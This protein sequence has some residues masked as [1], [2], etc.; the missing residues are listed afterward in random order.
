MN[1][2]ITILQSMAYTAVGD[3]IDQ[4]PL[5]PEEEDRA[6]FLAIIIDELKKELQALT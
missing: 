3:I 2:H 1:R 6:E 4:F 5:F